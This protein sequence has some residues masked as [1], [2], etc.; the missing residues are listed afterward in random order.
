MTLEFVLFWPDSGLDLVKV[1]ID[2]KVKVKID[3]KN[4]HFLMLF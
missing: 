1:K 3:T 2:T 4:G